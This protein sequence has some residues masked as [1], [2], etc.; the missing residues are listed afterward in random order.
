MATLGVNRAQL[1]HVHRKLHPAIDR[2]IYVVAAAVIV[3]VVVAGAAENA[4]VQQGSSKGAGPR[5]S[6]ASSFIRG[7]RRRLTS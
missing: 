6:V 4:S 3:A 2:H 1:L 5:T 7:C